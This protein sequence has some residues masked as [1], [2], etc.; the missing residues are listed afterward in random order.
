MK[1]TQQELYMRTALQ[2]AQATLGQTGTNPVVGCVIVNQGRIVGMGAHLQRGTAH[3]EV[4]ALQMAGEQAKG[5]TVYVT[6][7][8]CSH[9]GQTPPCALRLIEAGVKKVIVAAKDPNPLVAGRGIELLRE[10][11]IEVEVG[12]LAEESKK[13]NEKFNAFIV[14]RKPFV[15]L[16][17]ASTLDGK[18]ATESGDSKWISNEQARAVVHRLRHQHQAIMVGIGTVLKDDPALT[19]RMGVEGIHPT[20]IIVDSRLRTPLTSKVVL[21]R[22]AP[23]IILCSKQAPSENERQLSAHGVEVIRVGEGD[24]VDLE[25]AMLELGK[26][27]ISSILLEGGARLNGAMLEAGLVHKMI[28]FYAP[29]LV[30]GMHSPSLIQMNGVK[31]MDEAIAL[32]NIEVETFEDNI[33]IVGYPQ[34]GGE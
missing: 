22:S 33:C 2:M 19:T 28:L 1:Q 16:K 30:G 31:R 5:S 26:R 6:L 20:R 7:E 24:L 8:P 21:D 27:E 14:S 4:Q 10:H 12:L 15:T 3:A 23:T 34:Y 25:Q 11:G 9:Y 29:K 18:V 17:S 13:L 32:K